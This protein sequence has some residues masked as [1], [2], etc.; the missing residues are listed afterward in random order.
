VER[1]P[2]APVLALTWNPLRWC[3]RWR[4]LEERNDMTSERQRGRLLS[5]C[6]RLAV[7]KCIEC[8]IRQSRPLLSYSVS[9]SSGGSPGNAHRVLT[10][11]ATSTMTD[12]QQFHPERSIGQETQQI[13]R[14]TNVCLNGRPPEGKRLNTPYSFYF[15]FMTK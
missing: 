5:A 3:P 7:A 15:A 8:P 1:S 11:A 4:G 6:V 10:S 9:P 2:P 12:K 14:S 13:T